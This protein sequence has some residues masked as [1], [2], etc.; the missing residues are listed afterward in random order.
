MND[1][2]FDAICTYIRKDC[3]LEKLS[4]PKYLASYSFL[5]V[6]LSLSHSGRLH[7]LLMVHTEPHNALF[8][9]AINVRR[10]CFWSNYCW[11]GNSAT[12]IGEILPFW[13]NLQSLGQFSEG[14]FPVWENFGLTLAN[15]ICHRASFHWCKW[16]NVDKQS[17]HLV[18]LARKHKNVKWKEV[19]FEQMAIP[20]LM[21]NL[22]SKVF[23][24]S[25]W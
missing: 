22:K 6:S 18:T 5:L 19:E 23:L 24:E 8:K 3:S 13:Q 2:K 9:A 10:K 15:F 25:M 11:A 12:R 4:L 7:L 16:P 20:I 1:G 17:S 21:I 14:F